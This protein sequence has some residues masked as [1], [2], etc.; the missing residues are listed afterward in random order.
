[1]KIIYICIY[2]KELIKVWIIKKGG[3]GLEKIEEMIF[4]GEMIKK[5]KD[6]IIV[7]KESLNEIN[8]FIIIATEK[9]FEE[10]L[11]KNKNEVIPEVINTHWL[12]L[13]KED[14]HIIVLLYNIVYSNL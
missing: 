1:M 3:E 9:G 11:W 13:Y 10:K 4:I 7:K 5:K 14:V 12:E 2:F 8:D 6:I